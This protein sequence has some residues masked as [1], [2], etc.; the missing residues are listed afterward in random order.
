LWADTEARRENNEM[1]RNDDGGNAPS[2]TEFANWRVRWFDQAT[3]Q[4]RDVPDV[5]DRIDALLELWR[6]PVPGN[7]Q[8][9]IDPQLLGLGTGVAMRR[10]ARG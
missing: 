4:G 1:S 3:Y 10:P 5:D 8:R 7:W 6:V 9:T 2:P